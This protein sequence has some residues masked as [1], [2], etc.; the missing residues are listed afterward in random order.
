VSGAAPSPATL[1]AEVHQ[2]ID[3]AMP[4]SQGVW[5]RSAALLTRQALEEAVRAK[6]DAYATSLDD[7]PFRAQLLCLQGTIADND[8]AREANYFW[9]ALSSA[10]HHCGYELP[11]SATD[12]RGWLAGVERVVA[13]LE[14][15]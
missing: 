13:A 2:L 12:L 5:A 4:E 15:R 14:R 9:S 6:L 1:L 11:P 8:V 3:S 7:A 10:T